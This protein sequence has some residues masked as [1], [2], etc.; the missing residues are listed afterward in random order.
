M[1]WWLWVQSPVEANFLSGVFDLS[2]LQKHVRRVVGG[3]GKKSCVSTGVRKPGNTCA[4]R[5]RYDLS[6]ESG[7]KPH[8]TNQCTRQKKFRQIQIE[9]FTNNI[10]C[11]SNIGICFLKNIKDYGK[12]RKCWK[13][14]ECV[15]TLYLMHHFET[16][17]GPTWL[18]GE[19]F[20]S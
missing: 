18:S 5:T 17:P 9:A 6:C 14:P 4:S 1:T 13:T 19:V 12:R 11:D 8:T 20:D 10:L 7:V 3:F 16:A 15:V 2:P